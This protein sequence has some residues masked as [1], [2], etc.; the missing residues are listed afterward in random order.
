MRYWTEGEARAELPRVRLLV[1]ALRRAARVQA[2]ATGNGHGQ[3]ADPGGP[4]GPMPA[5]ADAAAELRDKSIV[6]RDTESGLLDFPAVTEAGTVYLLCWRRDEDDLGW[7][8][9][10]EEGFAGRKRLPV[11]PDL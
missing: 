11:P 7:W 2:G 4:A 3:R 8:H 5:A 1:D 9:F 10:A 6:L